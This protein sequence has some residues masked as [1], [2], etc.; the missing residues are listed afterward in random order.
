MT[1]YIYSILSLTGQHLA[2]PVLSVE[3]LE[4]FS[5]RSVS[6]SPAVWGLIDLASPPTGLRSCVSSRLAFF[7][8]DLTVA[9]STGKRYFPVVIL[10]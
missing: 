8:I 2:L 5:A 9:P 1:F 7:I 6:A 4:G 3:Q 10:D